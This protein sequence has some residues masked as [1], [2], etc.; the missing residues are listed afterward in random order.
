MVLTVWIVFGLGLAI[1]LPTMLTDEIFGRHHGGDVHTVRA[2]TTLP[3]VSTSQQQSFFGGGGEAFIRPSTD[4]LG[5]DRDH[6]F[7]DGAQAQSEPDSDRDD[8]PEDDVL[9]VPANLDQIPPM[10]VGRLDDLRVVP[11]GQLAPV[12]L[13]V[14]LVD[15]VEDQTLRGPIIPATEK[16]QLGRPLI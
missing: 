2:R 15:Q 16:A 14:V 7:R 3:P 8:A 11:I 1:A 10:A 5:L 4:D 9:L 12:G 13:L 6:S